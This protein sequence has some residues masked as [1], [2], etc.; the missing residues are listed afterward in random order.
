MLALHIPRCALARRIVRALRACCACIPIVWAA[1]CDLRS[2][3]FRKQEIEMETETD[4]QTPPPRFLS[5]TRTHTRTC[6]FSLARSL[7][8]SLKRSK[9]AKKLRQIATLVFA[10][11]PAR[12]QRSKRDLR[13]RAHLLQHVL[14]LQEVAQRPAPSLPGGGTRTRP[15]HAPVHARVAHISCGAVAH[16][17]LNKADLSSTKFILIAG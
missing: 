3:F 1:R 8:H 9:T 6:K 11:R 14:L 7:A 2:D 10:D 13:L 15:A 4:K 17:A 16:S 12:R 5:H